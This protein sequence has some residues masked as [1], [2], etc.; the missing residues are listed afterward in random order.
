MLDKFKAGAAKVA[1]QKRL[2]EA[3][4]KKTLSV[5][6]PFSGPSEWNGLRSRILSTPGVT[7]LDV[8]TLGADGAVVSL[9]FVGTPEDMQSSMQASGLN[10][11]RGG[12]GWQIS[13]I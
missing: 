6:V 13:P 12:D 5:R 8:S 9:T 11:S 4:A 10:L 7:G 2:N 3:N 1:D